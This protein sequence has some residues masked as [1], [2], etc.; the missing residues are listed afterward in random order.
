MQVLHRQQIGLV[1]GLVSGKWQQLQGKV[2]EERSMID[3][4][5]AGKMDAR[6]S[7]ESNPFLTLLNLLF[8]TLLMLIPR[9]TLAPSPIP[10]HPAARQAPAPV[11]GTAPVRFPVRFPV[12]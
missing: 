7:G 1:P 10:G 3:Q 2:A 9:L 8:H 5:E 4:E 6:P 11:P 12:Q